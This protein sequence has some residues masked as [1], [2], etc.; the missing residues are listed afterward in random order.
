[1]IKCLFPCVSLFMVVCWL[2]LAGQTVASGGS[3]RE[4]FTIVLKFNQS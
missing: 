3:V 2:G 4:A 1:M